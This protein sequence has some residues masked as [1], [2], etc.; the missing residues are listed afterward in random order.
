[1]PDQKSSGKSTGSRC[2][3]WRGRVVAAPKST[4]YQVDLRCSPSSPSKS[5][6]ASPWQHQPKTR[7]NQ[8]R[9]TGEMPEWF[10]SPGSRTLLVIR[11]SRGPFCSSKSRLASG[12]FRT[13]VSIV[14]EELR[15]R[16]F[17][18]PSGS[19]LGARFPPFLF[20]FHTWISLV[21]FACP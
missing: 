9:D 14:T 6:S 15:A 1:M 16:Q 4:S 7:T 19:I 18:V 3:P 12:T 17:V 10:P 5:F 8:A 21:R 13:F 20:C 2:F 11:A